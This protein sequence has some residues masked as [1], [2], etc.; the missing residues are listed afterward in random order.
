M[1][2]SPRIPGPL[3]LPPSPLTL[4]SLVRVSWTVQSGMVGTPIL[5]VKPYLSSIPSERLRRGWLADAEAVGP[6][7]SGP[8]QARG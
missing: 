1:A 8:R 3:L 4:S 6:A 2:P 5:D 7:G